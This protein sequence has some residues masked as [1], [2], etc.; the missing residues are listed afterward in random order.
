VNRL[1]GGCLKS[2]SSCRLTIRCRP[3]SLT[4]RGL[5]SNVG[6]TLLVG[7]LSKSE[8]LIRGVSRK[9]KVF[10]AMPSSSQR[11]SFTPR[12]RGCLPARGHLQVSAREGVAFALRS[13]VARQCAVFRAMAGRSSA[14]PQVW[15]RVP[16]SG[17]AA[18]VPRQACF[19][20]R[21]F[22]AAL[23]PASHGSAVWRI[24]LLGFR[25][26]WL[27]AR[28]HGVAFVAHVGVSL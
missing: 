14:P 2:E 24:Y 20:R 18:F 10:R 5:S 27:H 26:S 8:L 12:Q 25:M 6:G 16:L 19:S 23:C 9:G 15:M 3:T 22:C 7:E 4:G 13:E 1:C 28:R 17:R 21:E 11:Q